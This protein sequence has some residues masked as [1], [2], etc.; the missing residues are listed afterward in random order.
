MALWHGA[1]LTVKF[2]R[3][4]PGTQNT[5]PCAWKLFCVSYSPSAPIIFFLGENPGKKNPTV[6]FR[7]DQSLICPLVS[8][9]EFAK[10]LNIIS[11]SSGGGEGEKWTCS[12][13][14]PPVGPESDTGS[15]VSTVTAPVEWLSCIQLKL[16]LLWIPKPSSPFWCFPSVDNP[17]WFFISYWFL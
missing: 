6:P 5:T 1:K 16:F 12:L 3:L 15:L 8:G 2:H 17:W 10:S 11:W 14:T 9:F 7:P 13:H 4:C